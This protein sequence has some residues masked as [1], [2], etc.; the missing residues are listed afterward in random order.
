MPMVKDRQNIPALTAESTDD[1]PISARTRSKTV[2]MNGTE[3]PGSFKT[4]DQIVANDS[5]V[6]KAVKEKRLSKS[7]KSTKKNDVQM[8]KQPRNS[9]RLMLKELKKTNPQQLETLF[10]KADITWGDFIGGM[11]SFIVEKEPEKLKGLLDLEIFDF[12]NEITDITGPVLWNIETCHIKPVSLAV[13]HVSL[14]CLKILIRSEKFWELNTN[15]FIVLL[16]NLFQCI[17]IMNACNSAQFQEYLRCFKLLLS[18]G[19]SVGIRLWSLRFFDRHIHETSEHVQLLYA[20]G[21]EFEFDDE[22]VVENDSSGFLAYLERKS[23]SQPDSSGFYQPESLQDICRNAIR[24][25]LRNRYAF[26][27]NIFTF[28]KYF[29][30]HGYL[31]KTA[32]DFLVYNLSLDE[33]DSKQASPE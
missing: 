19:A 8:K 21:V 3:N 17:F 14:E 4:E 24:N 33:K 28:S 5:D 16:K 11:H 32:A 7:A 25:Y 31:T 10:G 15:V 29:G 13:N 26:A 12:D 20:A 27:T 22:D 2:V 18:C 6:K 30:K 9:K 23:K 1:R